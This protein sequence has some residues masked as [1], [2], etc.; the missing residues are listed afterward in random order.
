MQE[1]GSVRGEG[2]FE[3]DGQIRVHDRTRMTYDVSVHYLLFGV[4]LEQFWTIASFART[5][6]VNCPR[7]AEIYFPCRE[8]LRTGAHER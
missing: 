3:H 4:Y 6:Q 1:R 5:G 7:V 2:T 8:P